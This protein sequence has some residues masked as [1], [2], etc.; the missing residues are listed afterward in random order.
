MSAVEWSLD[1]HQS[2]AVRLLRA[3][4]GEDEDQ[5]MSA[6]LERVVRGAAER[7]MVER[8]LRVVKAI[9]G[10]QLQRQARRLQSRLMPDGPAR[11]PLGPVM[12]PQNGEHVRERVAVVGADEGRE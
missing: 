7:E 9:G 11:Q 2:R 3:G 10:E 1:R 12:K 8:L 6:G 4:I 5:E